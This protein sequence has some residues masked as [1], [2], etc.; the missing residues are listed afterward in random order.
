M[1]RRRRA[2]GSP[3]ADRSP[4]PQGVCGRPGSR[5]GNGCAGH[6]APTTADEER[7]ADGGHA[8]SPPLPH[9]G[10]G[11]HARPPSKRARGRTLWHRSV[12]R[13]GFP[14]AS[15]RSQL[16]PSRLPSGPH[17][18]WPSHTAGTAR[19][20]RGQAGT[21]RARLQGRPPCPTPA[22]GAAITRHL[23]VTVRAARR[24]Q[25]PLAELKCGVDCCL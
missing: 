17:L 11:H 10:S 25:P 6:A 3:A 14:A 5:E 1:A 21:A 22:H 9:P 16:T 2:E 13:Q 8:H 20:W 23:P 19:P 24:E 18:P 4:R 7:A 15:P 12:P